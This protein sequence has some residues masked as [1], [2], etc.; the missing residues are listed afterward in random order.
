[1]PARKKK[2]K[3]KIIKEAEAFVMK[4]LRKSVVQKIVKKAVTKLIPKGPLMPLTVLGTVE[5]MAQGSKTLKSTRS[6]LFTKLRAKDM[7]L[8]WFLIQG[9][10]D[11]IFEEVMLALRRAPTVR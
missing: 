1:M 3:A 4:R 6:T 5:Q 10:Y 8:L 2:A 9:D 11:E 7:D